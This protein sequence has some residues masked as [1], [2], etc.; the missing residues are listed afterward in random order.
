MN[1]HTVAF[2]PMGL[3][4]YKGSFDSGEGRC[5]PK[6]SDAEAGAVDSTRTFCRLVEVDVEDSDGTL[7][8]HALLRYADDLRSSL[9]ECHALH[10][11]RKLPSEQTFAGRNFPKS[12]GIIS[13]ARHHV[14]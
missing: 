9:V 2:D 7:V 8:T 6:G 10:S 5:A 4:I 12:Q 11:G 13:S 14:F 3:N 1:A